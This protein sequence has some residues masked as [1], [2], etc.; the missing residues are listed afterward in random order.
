MK[1]A[2]ARKYEVVLPHRACNN[3]RLNLL[4]RTNL[5]NQPDNVFCWYKIL[6]CVHMSDLCTVVTK[7]SLGVPANNGGEISI[8][9]LNDSKW[10]KSNP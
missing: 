7:M 3:L 2:F 4:K 6:D 1:I 10:F 8:N 9:S 5:I